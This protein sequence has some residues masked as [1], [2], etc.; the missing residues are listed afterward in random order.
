MP[1]NNF[2]D[3]TEEWNGSSWTEISDLNAAKSNAATSGTSTAMLAAGGNTPPF[4]VNTENWDG[5]SW[6]EVAN[7]A[8]ARAGSSTTP[9]GTS[10]AALTAG[11]SNPSDPGVT[12]TGEEWNVPTALQTLAST[13]A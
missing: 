10:L 13:N 2:K 6:T 12:T 1:P 8:G 7:L 4:T 11:G 3:E 9:A 5:S